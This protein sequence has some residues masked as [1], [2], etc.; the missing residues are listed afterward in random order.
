MTIKRNHPVRE[1]FSSRSTGNDRGTYYSTKGHAINAF[2]GILQTF[3][4]WL[5]RDDL[6]DFSGNEGRK[7]IDV[8]ANDEGIVGCA[9]FSWFRMESGR[10]EFIGYLA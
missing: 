4:M 3:D 7:T 2:D 6:A 5:D 1:L 10:Y 9:V 8:Y